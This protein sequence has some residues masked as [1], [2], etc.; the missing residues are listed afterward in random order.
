MAEEQFRRAL[1]ITQ[2]DPSV[3]FT[4]PISLFFLVL[5]VAI[6]LVPWIMRK[7]GAGGSLA[8]AAS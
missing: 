3:F 5:A 8:E 4:H 6:L 2:G 7:L 1:M